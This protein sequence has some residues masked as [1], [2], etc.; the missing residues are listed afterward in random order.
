MAQRRSAGTRLGTKLFSKRVLQRFGVSLLLMVMVFLA[1]S[2]L[3]GFVQRAW[4]EHQLNR[5]IEQQAAQNEQQ[6]A[7]NARLKGAADF[8][9]SDVAAE[10]AARERLGMA[11]EGEMVLLPTIVV[12]QSPTAIPTAEAEAVPGELSSK[13]ANAVERQTNV[14]RWIHAL[15]P[16][17]DTVP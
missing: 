9:E 8:A 4:Q 2:L 3:V 5:A 12:P 14:A 10:Q 6:R 13:A 15:F 1:G 7:H 17:R 11:R 16:G